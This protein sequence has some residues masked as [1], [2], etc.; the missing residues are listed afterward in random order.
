MCEGDRRGVFAVLT[1]RG[2]AALERAAVDHVET[3]REYFVDLIDPADLEA[4]GRA[5]RT[6]SKRLA[7]VR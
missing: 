3:V 6:I 4:I 2:F 1:N 5:F 7:Q